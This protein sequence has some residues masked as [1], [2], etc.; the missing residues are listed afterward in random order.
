MTAE[1]TRDAI[2]WM[3]KYYE[4]GGTLCDRCEGNFYD[5]Q[6]NVGWCRFAELENVIDCLAPIPAYMLSDSEI[7]ER[8]CKP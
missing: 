2:K 4:T 7:A 1:T 5:P 3:D 8:I 6:L